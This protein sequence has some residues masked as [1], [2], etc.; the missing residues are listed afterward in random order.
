M[1]S[2][3]EMDSRS[4]RLRGAPPTHRPS[5]TTTKTRKLDILLSVLYYA[6]R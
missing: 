5:L 6:V 1:R 2:N 3:R 4:R